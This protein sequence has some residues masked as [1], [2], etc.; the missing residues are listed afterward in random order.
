MTET[1]VNLDKDAVREQARGRWP[2]VIGTLAPGLRDTIDHGH[3]KHGPC[4]VHGGKDGLR[5]LPDFADTGG[6]VCNTCGTKS[7]GY[8]TIM[9]LCGWDFPATVAAVG[10]ALGMTTTNGDRPV[11]KP[12]VPVVAT[13]TAEDE[14]RT[15]EHARK[16]LAR[17]WKE[18]TSD[19]GR[20]SE[21]LRSRGLSGDV[22][23]ALR[24]HPALDYF[25]NDEP[26]KKSGAYPA[27]VAQMLD[28]AGYAVAL[29]RIYLA[30]D[31]PG[32][33]PV[34]APKKT[35]MPTR[36]GATTGAAIRLF[37]SADELGIAEGI[38]TALAIQ[39]ATGMPVWSCVTAHG[40]ETVVLPASVKRVYVWADRDESHTGQKAAE[41]A[42]ARFTTEGR[43]A[44]VILPPPLHE[45]V[46]P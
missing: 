29:H 25:N 16:Q 6:V 37:D 43:E 34:P 40:L 23:A 7:D 22:P 13:R 45:E 36:E 3:R 1:P 4:P 38:E 8:A 32:K 14:T 19:T 17:V 33:A 28:A 30:A 18:T 41:K 2:D 15:R 20:G 27:L 10:D 46:K 5:V 39:E 11:V 44:F 26:P 31:G 35:M 9:W 12:P 21:Y 42:A 24:L